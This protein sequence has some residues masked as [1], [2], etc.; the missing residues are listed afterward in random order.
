MG[1]SFASE[2]MNIE[3]LITVGEAF[4]RGIE[5]FDESW[6]LSYGQSMDILWSSFGSATA[7]SLSELDFRLQVEDI[8]D[9]LDRIGW[10]SGASIE[11]LNVLRCSIL[12]V[13]KP[14]SRSVERNESLQVGLGLGTLGLR[15]LTLSGCTGFVRST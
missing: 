9:R 3:A 7:K 13:S 12:R 11:Q 1:K 4:S 14:T 15:V 5:R 10:S 8:S 6:R 2:L